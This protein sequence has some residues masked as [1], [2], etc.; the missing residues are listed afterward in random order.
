M[1]PS[2]LSPINFAYV[3]SFMEGNNFDLIK[4]LV[5]FPVQFVLL[6]F[7]ILPCLQVTGSMLHFIQLAFSF[8]SMLDPQ[9]LW[10]LPFQMM[11]GSNP[12]VFFQFH[13][14]K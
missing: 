4:I 12:V 9:L 7:I 14:K 11:L 3:I 2:V 13:L 1:P 6:M 10:Y 5:C 8:A